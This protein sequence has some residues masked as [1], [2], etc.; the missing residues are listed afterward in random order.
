[1]WSKAGYTNTRCGRQQPSTQ[2]SAPFTTGGPTISKGGYINDYYTSASVGGELLQ[3]AAIPRE[4]IQ[5]IPSHV[6]GRERTFSSAIALRDWFRDNTPVHTINVVTEGAH[7][8][9]TRLLYRKAVGRNVTVAIIAVSN[10]D[11]NPKQ[12]WRYSDGVR[13]V[14]GES[15][16]YIY[17][18]FFFYPSASLADKEPAQTLRHLVD[19]LGT[20]MSLVK[21]CLDA[22]QAY[23]GLGFKVRVGMIEVP[24]PG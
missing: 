17:A 8:R 9:R 1:M 4:A 15:I 20:W 22:I 18:K 5:M 6:N 3:K 19:M 12:W 10:A 16:A 13:E 23:G 14:I 7:A 11:Y 2:L 21:S 24:S